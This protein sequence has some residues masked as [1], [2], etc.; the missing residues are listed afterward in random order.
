V[1]G[2][3]VALDLPGGDAFV[4]ALNTVW[5][6]G[7]AVLPLD[8]RLPAAARQHLLTSLA[9]TH[10]LGEDG[11]ERVLDG[12]RG[13][14]PGDA[15]V[16]AT[17]GSTG[18]PRGVVLTHAAVEASAQA[19]SAALEVSHDDHW[20]ACLPLSH[21]G[22]LSV[23]T[24]A[25]H[26]GTRLTVLPSA[27]PGAIEAT[28]TGAQPVTLVS[29]V[30]TL[31]QRVD[32]DRFRRVLLGGSRPPAHRPPHVIATY[33]L[34]ETGSGIVYDGWPL[35]GVELRVDA[36]GVIEVRCPMLLRCYRDGTVPVDSEGW[37]STGDV[38]GFETDGRLRVQGRRGDLIIT[39]GENVWPDP[40]EAV[41][42]RH[43]QVAEV[44][45][46]GTP[47]PEWGQVVTA[48]VVAANPSTPPTL[49]TLRHHVR[50]HL[51]AFCAPR[52]VEFVTSLPRTPLGKIRR[53]ALSAGG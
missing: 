2:R 12:G 20:L 38:G 37:F 44:A 27:D 11:V 26:T 16:M 45:V 17:S 34:T 42:A 52:R 6:R 32:V 46:T 30:P 41:L 3:L 40:V 15:L 23:I 9:P 13:T 49:D 50:E 39:G 48:W 7:D 47:D 28:T 53:S 14:E 35:P 5:A 22:G 24:R 36:T 51:P 21:V 33:G 29:L 18:E 1:T 10:V 43:P 31:L 25:L 19:S 4:A 8:Q